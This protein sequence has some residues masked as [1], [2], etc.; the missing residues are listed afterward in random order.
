M[1][2]K[3]TRLGKRAQ[4]NLV[5]AD[6]IFESTMNLTW[7]EHKRTS[8]MLTVRINDESYLAVDE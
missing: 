4:K 1:I 5:H 8:F 2:A 3:V 6:Y 7:L